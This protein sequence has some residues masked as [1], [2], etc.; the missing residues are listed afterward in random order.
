MGSLQVTDTLWMV[1]N[2]PPAT[3]TLQIQ[4]FRSL[5]SSRGDLN[6]QKVDTKYLNKLPYT[7]SDQDFHYVVLGSVQ[8]TVA[9]K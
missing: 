2:P 8:M 3:D 6:S 1:N 9:K 4:A 7:S 5:S